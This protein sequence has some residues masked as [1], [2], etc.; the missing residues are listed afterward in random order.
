MEREQLTRQLPQRPSQ[1]LCYEFEFKHDASV[2][3]VN[4]LG[5]QSTNYQEGNLQSRL[6]LARKIVERN[7]SYMQQCAKILPNGE[8]VVRGSNICP[9]S[10]RTQ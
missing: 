8:R 4:R 2:Y 9:S 3:F 10:Y 7:Q 5:S 1:G 6:R